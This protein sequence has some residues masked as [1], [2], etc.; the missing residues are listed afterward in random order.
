MTVT[1][2]PKKQMRSQLIRSSKEESVIRLSVTSREVRLASQYFA[3]TTRGSPI[4]AIPT[5]QRRR[6]SSENCGKTKRVVTVARFNEHAPRLRY[7][8]RC[9]QNGLV[10]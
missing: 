6:P 10:S 3:F 8:T 2:A 5:I 7:D 1:T 9:T 4:G